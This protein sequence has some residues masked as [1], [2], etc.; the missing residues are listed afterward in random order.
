LGR[1]L[2]D[3][4]DLDIGTGNNPLGSVTTR[5]NP[6]EAVVFA[7]ER[8]KIGIPSRRLRKT[9]SRDRRPRVLS[10]SWSEEAIER[11]G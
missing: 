3:V 7:T 10:T 9:K 6:P 8:F 4:L 11:G 1:A 2:R 5:V